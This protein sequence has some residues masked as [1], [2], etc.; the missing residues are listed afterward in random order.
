[1]LLRQTILYLP[2][3]V[4]GPL[5]QLLASLLWT[6]FLSPDQIGLFALTIAAQELVYSAT[7]SWFTLYTVRH[8]N[9]QSDAADRKAFLET[10]AVLL[11][12]TAFVNALVMLALPLI[13]TGAWDASLVAAAMTYCVLRSFAN[14][15]ADRARAASDA[16]AYSV[17]QVLWPVGGVV[18]GWIAVAFFAP[19]AA[20][21]VWAQ[22]LAQFV[23]LMLVLWRLGVA[24]RLVLSTSLVRVAFIYAGPLVAGSVFTWFANNGLRF[25][26][27]HFQGTAAVGLVTV[28]WGLGLRGAMFAAML[29]TAAAFPLA[30]ARAR[31]GGMA[32]G[33]RQLVEN[34]VLLLAVIAPASAGL[35]AICTPLSHFIVA[36]PFREMTAEV[37]PWAVLAGAARNM[38]VH[39]CQQVFLLRNETVVA[40]ATDVVDGTASMIGAVVG[41]LL[42]GLPG[43]LM[44]AAAGACAA[45]AVSAVIGAMRHDFTFPLIDL[46]KIAGSAL[47]MVVIVR[48]LPVRPEFIS[49]CT[50]IATGAVVYGAALAVLYPERAQGLWGKLCAK[51]GVLPR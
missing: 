30:V 5:A 36:A 47:A 13:I 6:Y 24:R 27:A 46:M 41:L 17:L 10:E 34:G 8:F 37:L 7:L 12:A 40:F 42:A 28:G 45:L 22:A 25:V 31:E 48:A 26:V 44:G 21:L 50:A 33:Q 11:A 39:F 4:V 14:H 19:T 51:I 38:R 3:Q 16:F 15:L 32:S 9:P 29:V 20:A 2:A 35:W 49:L 23:A 43:C 1:M 18:L